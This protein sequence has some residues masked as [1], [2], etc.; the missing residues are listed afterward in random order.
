MHNGG[1]V[2]CD[3]LEKPS[4]K[5]LHLE[6]SMLIHRLTVRPKFKQLHNSKRETTLQPACVCVC[7]MS[8]VSGGQTG[9]CH[10]A[11]SPLTGVKIL[12]AAAPRLI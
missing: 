5:N 10:W 11:S 6:K 9:V 8:L 3:F 4:K 7:L 1:S 2:R 12:S